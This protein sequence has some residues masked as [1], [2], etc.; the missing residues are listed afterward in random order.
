MA[1]AK[2]SQCDTPAMVTIS[3]NPLCVDHWL[4]FQQATQIQGN[5][6]I[7]YLNYLSDQAEL[8]VG[9]PGILPRYKVTQP[10]FN[11]GTMNFQNIRI[12]KS[13]VG[14]VNTGVIGKLDTV[15][16]VIEKDGNSEL[17]EGIKQF[18]QA[19]I[20]AKEVDTELKKEIVDQISF[21][22]TQAATPKEKR[23]LSVV[24]IVIKS[25]KVALTT[26]EA[27]STLMTL[28]DKLAVLFAIAIDIKL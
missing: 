21:L 7:E 4:K 19:V 6:E 24:K 5:R 14:V 20:D 13:N 27:V 28:W 3:N 26:T 16:S 1:K 9:L 17:T 2:C 10:V 23:M 8:A 11:K 18:T 25:I 12:D 15:M 22:A